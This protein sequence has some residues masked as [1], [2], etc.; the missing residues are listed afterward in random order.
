MGLLSKLFGKKPNI[1]AFVGVDIDKEQE[2][3][4]DAN[5]RNVGKAGKL[6]RLAAEQDQEALLQ[7]M[8][9]GISG[10]DKFIGSQKNVAEDFL[11]GRVPGD[12]AAKIADKAASRG[13]SSGTSGSG[14]IR[15]LEARD[16]GLTSLD[17]MQR[18]YDM[19]ERFVNQQHRTVA[20]KVMQVSSMFQTPAQRLAHKTQERDTKWT[21]DYLAAKTA[22]APD[23]R[24]SGLLNTGMQAAGM[25]FGHAGT[26]AMANAIGG[27]QQAAAP[28]VAAP[29]AAAPQAAAPAMMNDSWWGTPAQSSWYGPS[30]P[31]YGPAAQ[32]S[33]PDLSWYSQPTAQ[34]GR[35]MLNMARGFAPF[36]PQQGTNIS[37]SATSRAFGGEMLPAG[38]AMNQM[39]YGAGTPPQ[40]D[41]DKAMPG[42]RIE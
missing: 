35:S 24:F 14:A 26:M 17:L 31:V 20:P 6:A 10:Y 37:G 2:G 27:R 39:I 30:A 38:A 29:Q 16:L 8:R 15:N 36:M 33:I 9:G 12:L 18:G 40:L 32:P 1:P 25:Y 28:Q 11:S 21:R 41:I 7:V 5:L 19:A 4:I 34:P 3:A 42:F 13:I 23:P 22:A